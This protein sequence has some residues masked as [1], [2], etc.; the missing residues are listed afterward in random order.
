MARY[1]VIKD[2]VAIN[3]IE[4]DADFAQT[5]GAI[6]AGEAGIGWLWDGET[7]TA[8]PEQIRTKEV[9]ISELAEI[10][11]K[12]IR[13]LRENNA[14]RLKELEDQAQALR[15]ELSAIK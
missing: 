2:C 10:D 5:I 13:A 3:C 4:A 6:P 15:L 9:I 8:P 11:T 1:L 7:L 12:S 14:T